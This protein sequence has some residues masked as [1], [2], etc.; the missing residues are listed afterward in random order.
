VGGITKT[1]ASYWESECQA[2]KSSLVALD[3]T[4]MG[5]VKLS[6]FYGANSDGEWRFG[7]SE[8]YLRELGAL[9]ESSAWRGKEVIIPNYLQGASNCIVTTENYLVCCVSECESVLNEVED[10]IGSAVASPDEIIPLVRGISS[11]DDENPKLDGALEQQLR[12]IAET[13]SGQVPLHGR[14][15]AQWLHYVFPRECPFPHKAGTVTQAAPREYGGEMLASQE[16]VSTHA[17]QR[18]N[19]LSPELMQATETAQWMTQWS[20]EE[21]L[22]VEYDELRVPW[23]GHRLAVG[24]VAVLLLCAAYF[25]GSPKNAKGG[26]ATSGAFE[27]RAHFV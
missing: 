9:D 6:D 10:A 7:E 25:A 21:E 5:R 16:E 23:S 27:P 26:H 14:L 22:H 11:Y 2:I 20:E 8:A 3:K 15:F 4:G 24:G 1:F 12:R 19:D 13:H 17:S 18:G